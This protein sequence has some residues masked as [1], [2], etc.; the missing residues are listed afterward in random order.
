MKTLQQEFTPSRTS[1]PE[2]ILDESSVKKGHDGKERPYN[3][4]IIAVLTGRCVST[5]CSSETQRRYT[6]SV[7]VPSKSLKNAR[8]GGFLNSNCF[9]AITFATEGKG[10]LPF[11]I[12]LVVSSIVILS[13]EG[14]STK[15]LSRRLDLYNL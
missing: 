3:H 2:V 4:K 12:G 15:V 14:G 5:E 6:D 13:P 8:I 1:H 9:D 11:A 10:S 7:I